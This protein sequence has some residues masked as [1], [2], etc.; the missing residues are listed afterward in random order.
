MTCVEAFDSNHVSWHDQPY[1]MKTYFGMKNPPVNL[2]GIAIG[3]GTIGAEGEFAY[4]P[5]V[6]TYA[7][8]N[9]VTRV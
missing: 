2:A 3:D 9:R 6:T 8:Y 1:I 7:Y 5:T 4:M